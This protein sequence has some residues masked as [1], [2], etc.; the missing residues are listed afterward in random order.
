M[1]TENFS[2]A[3][4]S[5]LPIFIGAAE[6]VSRIEKKFQFIFFG[7]FLEALD[8]ASPA[9]EID[10]D[11]ARRAGSDHPLELF[12]VNGPG[13]IYVAKDRGYFLVFKGMSGCYKCERWHYDLS[14]KPKRSYGYLQGRRPIT[15][16]DAVPYADRLN[17]F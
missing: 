17:N 4:V 7:D 11:Y 12:R 14:F 6:C 1:K 15:C 3:E 16:G 10:P 9:P 2:I 13:F 8:L 5:Y